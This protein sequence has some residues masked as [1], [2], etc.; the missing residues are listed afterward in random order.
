MFAMEAAIFVNCYL[1]QFGSYPT[2]DLRCVIL[3][4]WITSCS[5]GPCNALLWSVKLSSTSI[6]GYRWVAG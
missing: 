5:N 3:L 4:G 1:C 2:S 6:L